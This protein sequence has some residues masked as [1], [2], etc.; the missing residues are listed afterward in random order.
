M[1]MA[2]IWSTTEGGGASN[3][4]CSSSLSNGDAGAGSRVNE[5]APP[6]GGGSWPFCS[7]QVVST[8]DRTAVDSLG[9]VLAAQLLLSGEQDMV[10]SPFG[11]ANQYTKVFPKGNC[12]WMFD[13]CMACWLQEPP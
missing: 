10:C 2:V 11:S 13:I 1:G 6:T 5:V 4:R 8:Q 9:W 12:L 7:G 3:G